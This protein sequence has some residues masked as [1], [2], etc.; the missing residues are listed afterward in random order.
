MRW[1]DVRW[2]DARRLVPIQSCFGRNRLDLDTVFVFLA[3]AKTHREVAE[4]LKLPEVGDVWL[5]YV[6]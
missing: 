3:S 6:K 5:S 1:C 4:A 2:R